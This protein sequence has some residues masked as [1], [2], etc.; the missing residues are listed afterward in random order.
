MAPDGD[1][2][3][4]GELGRNLT[5]FG[6]EL[7]QIR[8]AFTGYVLIGVYQAEQEA[9]KARVKQLEESQ[10]WLVRTVVGFVIVTVMAAVGVGVTQ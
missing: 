8:E 9:L 6:D 4:L 7:R 2:I 3:T 5:R 10:V 1:D